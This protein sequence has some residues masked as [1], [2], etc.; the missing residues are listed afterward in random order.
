MG[1]WTKKWSR[2]K[3]NICIKDGE[4]NFPGTL[5]VEVTFS[6][7]DKNEFKLSYKVKTFKKT[8]INLT[9]HMFVN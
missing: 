4:E 6:L 8:I 5:T 2:N 9:H 1:C 7:N 3:I